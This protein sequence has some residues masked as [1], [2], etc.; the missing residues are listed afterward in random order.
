MARLNRKRQDCS[1]GHAVEA[2]RTFMVWNAT[3]QKV[4]HV[5]DGLCAQRKV[6]RMQL[7]LS[8]YKPIF[9]EAVVTGPATVA[10]ATFY[11]PSEAPA[12]FLYGRTVGQTL[13][14]E[15]NLGAAE[16]G[17]VWDPAKFLFRTM[18]STSLRCWQRGPACALERSGS[19]LQPAS[20]TNST[21]S[22]CTADFQTGSADGSGHQSGKFTRY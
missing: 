13:P 3:M 19:L 21:P 4:S 8:V 7:Q 9:V 11:T 22:F 10:N 6:Y 1:D 17:L 12:D 15:C 14:N 18:D 16:N 5:Q 2:L 20:T